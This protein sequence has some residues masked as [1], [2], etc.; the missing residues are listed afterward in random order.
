MIL[1]SGNNAELV[2]KIATYLC[3]QFRNIWDKIV[4]RVRVTSLYF[5]LNFRYGKYLYYARNENV[6]DE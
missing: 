6:K 5:L 4:S 2:Y 1:H 3:R